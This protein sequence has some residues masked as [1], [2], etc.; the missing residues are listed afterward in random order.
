MLKNE[1]FFSLERLIFLRQCLMFEWLKKKYFLLW[2]I[3]F[4]LIIYTIWYGFSV[5]NEYTHSWIPTETFPQ[6]PNFSFYIIEY[7][8]L[9]F[10]ALFVFPFIIKNP[11]FLIFFSIWVSGLFLL[12]LRR[13]IS[14]F[15]RRRLERLRSRQ[16]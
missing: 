6:R 2:F 10:F 1:R 4:P 13:E 7:F 15:L 8:F 9:L 11:L 12:S 16:E 3:G 5:Y 14:I